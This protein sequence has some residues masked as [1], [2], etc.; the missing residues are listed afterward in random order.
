MI[1]YNKLLNIF[2]Q[3]S[4]NHQM[5]QKFGT[6]EISDMNIFEGTKF[7]IMWVTPQ[8]FVLKD[9]TLDYVVRVFIFDI[10]Q[11]SNSNE[12]ELISD[13]LQIISDV[14]KVFKNE[15]SGIYIDGDVEIIP[16][17][18]HLTDYTTGVYADLTIEVGYDSNN[19][20]DVKSLLEN[21]DIVI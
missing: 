10:L 2:Q 6:G 11:K 7:P 8:N 9:Q 14:I 3:I 13:T 21:I 12:T 19:Y 15:N 17:T 4:D 5:I 1:T 20:C 18:K 16:F